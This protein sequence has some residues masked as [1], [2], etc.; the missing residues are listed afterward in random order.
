MDRIAIQ[1]ALQLQIDAL[2]FAVL[3]C[4]KKHKRGDIIRT[5]YDAFSA[6]ELAHPFSVVGIAT[7]D[8]IARAGRTYY[9]VRT[10]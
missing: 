10:D 1:S 4:R 9:K 3:G 7:A 5:V 2:G 8:E 6:N